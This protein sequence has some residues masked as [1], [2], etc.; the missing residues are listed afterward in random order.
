MP[1]SRIARVI[2][3][4]TNRNPCDLIDVARRQV[5]HLGPIG[6]RAKRQQTNAR[7]LR[8]GYLSF[9]FPTRAMRQNFVDRVEEHCHP[10]VSVR[11]LRKKL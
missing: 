2:V 9:S 11:L 10:A 4:K 7:F 5:D 8:Q 1:F 6:I 3:G